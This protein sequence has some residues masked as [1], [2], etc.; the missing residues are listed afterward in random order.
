MVIRGYL[1]IGQD[2][3]NGS[4]RQFRLG[5]NVSFDLTIGDWGGK[6]ANST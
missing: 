2:P 1:S 6:N 3:N 4:A 5:Y